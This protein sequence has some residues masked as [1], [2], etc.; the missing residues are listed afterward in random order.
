MADW[1]EPL[2]GLV[3]AA[4]REAKLPE[5]EAD[6]AFDGDALVWTW[7]APEG[8]RSARAMLRAHLDAFGEHVS[9][10]LLASAD[11]A[12]HPEVAWTEAYPAPRIRVSS[13]DTPT[14]VKALAAELANQLRTAWGDARQ[15]AGRLEAVMERRRAA[16]SGLRKAAKEFG[17]TVDEG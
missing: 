6:G 9:M 2:V 3:H 5:P 14:E 7:A 12:E 4:A 13:F 8:G 1:V 10:R 11:L 17:F 15:N 16:A